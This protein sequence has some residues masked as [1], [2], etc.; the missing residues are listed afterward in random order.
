MLRGLPERLTP[1]QC[2]VLAEINRSPLPKL[3]RIGDEAFAQAMKLLDTLPRRRD[4][5]DG[6]EVRYRVYEIGLRHLPATQIWWSVQEAIKRCKFCPSVREFLDIA[7]QWRRS[8]EASEVKREAARLLNRE[9]I[10]RLADRKPAPPLTQDMVDRMS[11][12]EKRLGL[13]CGAL[14][15]R[16]DKIIPNPDPIGEAA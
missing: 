6:G 9:R 7:D 12:D 15:E 5:A 4:D 11:D 1:D 16:G 3:A 2:K 8:D 14:V 10:R 13:T